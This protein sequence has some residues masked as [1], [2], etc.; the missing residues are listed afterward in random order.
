MSEQTLPNKTELTAEM[1]RQWLALNAA[2]EQMSDKQ[3]TTI[4]DAAGWTVKDHLIHLAVWERSVLV[5]LKGRPRYEGLG[6]DEALYR[7]GDVDAV[8]AAIQQNWELVSLE[9]VLTRLREI[10]G[11]LM[12]EIE[13]LSD[14]DLLL[15]FTAY[16]PGEPEMGD[17][18]L[19]EELII[20]NT[21]DHFPEHI[22]WMET[23]VAQE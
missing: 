7:S 20:G 5:V 8:N 11:E 22:E 10:H 19:L 3:M 17:G 14:A 12:L 15:P 6:V 13:K 1:E 23:L 4:R 2:L 18:R 21:V 16:L 9:D